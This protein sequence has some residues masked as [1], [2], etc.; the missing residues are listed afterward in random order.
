MGMYNQPKWEYKPTIWY[1]APPN[2]DGWYHKGYTPCWDTPKVDH[3]K[4]GNSTQKQGFKNDSTFNNQDYS[5]SMGMRTRR[6]A[7]LKRSCDGSINSWVYK[8][9]FLTGGRHITYDHQPQNLGLNQMSTDSKKSGTPIVLHRKQ[10]LNPATFWHCP[11]PINL[12]YPLL[13]CGRAMWIISWNGQ[14]SEENNSCP[15]PGVMDRLYILT[16]PGV[17][18]CFKEKRLGNNTC[19]CF[20]FTALPSIQLVVVG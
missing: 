20:L 13:V 12:H 1:R 5:G 7:R 16:C 18:N 6:E 4:Y 19:F 8:P 15:I 14:L 3:P 9:T 2:S 11:P 10:G 17:Q